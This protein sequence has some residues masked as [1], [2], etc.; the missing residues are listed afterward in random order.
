MRRRFAFFEMKPG[1]E[2]PQ[3]KAYQAD[4]GSDSL[5]RVISCVEELNHVI[6]S[7][8]SLGAGFC[9]GH[10]YFCNLGEDESEIAPKLKVVVKH[11]IIPMLREYW[12]DD[13]QKANEWGD[14]LL[15]AI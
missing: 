9:I 10:S 12:F 4:I 6:E 13:I 15:R 3:F 7:D 1:F 11:D 2:T 14:K 5:D 8:Q